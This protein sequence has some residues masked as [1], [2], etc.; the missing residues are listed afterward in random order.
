MKTNTKTMITKMIIKTKMK[1]MDTMMKMYMK[2][3]KKNTN[4]STL[5]S[6]YK[7]THVRVYLHIHCV[8]GTGRCVMSDDKQIVVR[9][10]RVEYRGPVPERVEEVRGESL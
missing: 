8:S 1:K 7:H 10:S 9:E 6:T 5:T 2:V 3:K 4:T